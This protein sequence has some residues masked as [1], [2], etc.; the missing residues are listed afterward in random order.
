[1]VRS[2]RCALSRAGRAARQ[3][4]RVLRL[5]SRVESD[6]GNV[7]QVWGITTVYSSSSNGSGLP[8]LRWSHG[9]GGSRCSRGSRCWLRDDGLHAPYP[10]VLEPHLDATWVIR[11]V[12]E[13]I[14]HYS[15]RELASRL[16]L[17]LHHVYR[18][19]R[20][21]LLPSRD[22]HGIKE[23]VLENKPRVS[24][25]LMNRVGKVEIGEI[26]VPNLL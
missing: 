1:M 12:R 9:L 21:D 22:G 3:F 17:L 19:A 10:P 23:A 7:C 15:P 11:R 18:G 25:R 13:N 26:F 8:R 24:V 4:Q 20:F 16:I 14:L 6:V 5:D 2:N